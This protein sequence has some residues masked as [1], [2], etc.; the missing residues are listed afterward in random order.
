MASIEIKPTS[1]T[2]Y[3]NAIDAMTVS[4]SFKT[5]QAEGVILYGKG[6][7]SQDY[8]M[9]KIQSRNLLRAEINLGSKAD[10]ADVN[11]KGQ[12]DDDKSHSVFMEFNRKEISLTVDGISASSKRDP[13]SMF[14]LDLEGESM[15]L[16]GGTDKAQGFTGCIQGLVS[17]SLVR[18]CFERFQPDP[19]TLKTARDLAFLRINF[20]MFLSLV[21]AINMRISEQF[22]EAALQSIDRCLFVL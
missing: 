21:D 20:D 12:F 4:L 1:V 13:T 16:G 22:V 17:A 18:Y 9:I 6:K 8:V 2:D 5:T 15:R 19:P 7:V 3:N 11:I 10:F 14:Y